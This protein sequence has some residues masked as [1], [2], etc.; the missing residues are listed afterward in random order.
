MPNNG[1]SL[2]IVDA[3]PRK[4]GGIKGLKTERFYKANFTAHE[5]VQLLQVVV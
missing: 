4:E 1:S 3:F 2:K 5:R